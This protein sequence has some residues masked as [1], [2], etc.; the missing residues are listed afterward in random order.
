VL[1][2]QQKIYYEESEMLSEHEQCLSYKQSSTSRG[3]QNVSKGSGCFQ[4]RYWHKLSA[5]RSSRFSIPTQVL[6]MY[7]IQKRRTWPMEI[8]KMCA[9]L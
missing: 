1:K 7:F 4:V 3:F 9:E 8:R 6:P 5:S 2:F